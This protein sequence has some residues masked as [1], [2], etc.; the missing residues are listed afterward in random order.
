M[1][2]LCKISK[3]SLLV[4]GILYFLFYLS[5]S[6]IYL[7]SHV[8]QRLIGLFQFW[9][10]NIKNLN[11][12]TVFKNGFVEPAYLFFVANFTFSYLLELLLILYASLLV[13]LE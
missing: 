3:V 12:V 1:G 2:I 4:V 10:K 13:W 7:L 9:F 8:R 5:H 6:G 11:S